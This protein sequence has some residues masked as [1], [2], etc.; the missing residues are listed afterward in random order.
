[1]SFRHGSLS[2]KQEK[3]L[4]VKDLFLL[5]CC[6]LVGEAVELCKL[7]E[8]CTKVQRHL[9]ALFKVGTPFDLRKVDLLYSAALS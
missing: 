4:V 5:L 7:S 2:R 1:M 6:A 8:C 9:G 3:V